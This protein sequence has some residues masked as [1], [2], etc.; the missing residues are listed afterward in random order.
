MKVLSIIFL[1]LFFTINVNASEPITLAKTYQLES[2]IL[3]EQRSFS[4]YL[5]PSYNQSP[6]QSYPVIYLLDG[7]QTHLKAVA[8]LVEALSTQRLEQQIQQAIIVAI[9]NSQNAIRERDF[10]PTNVDWTFNGELLEKFENIGN[11]ANY[12]AFFEKELIPLINKNYRTSTK[13][14]LIGESFGGLFAS[15]VLLTNHALFTDYLIIDAT[16]LWDN[17]YLNR[18]F[19]EQQLI[20]K[21]LN[22]NV[23]FTFANNDEA[24][25]E[26]GKANY[27]WGVAFANKLKAHPS[28]NLI[29]N[30]RYFKGETHGTVA[31]LS[32]YYGIKELL[33]P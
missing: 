15:Y 32:W 8:G 31:A 21:P 10:T 20:N 24:F 6:N 17:N 7:D 29:I 18:Y 12:S 22:G 19:D 25:G 9:P 16:Y 4:V 26:I 11:A 23:Y 27:Q 30:Q 5:P 14:V 3:N 33:P 13:R 2:V 1:Y 28:N